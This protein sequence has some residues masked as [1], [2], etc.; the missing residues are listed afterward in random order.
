MGKRLVYL[1]GLVFLVPTCVLAFPSDT[2]DPLAASAG[3]ASGSG[4]SSDH[5][6]RR[7]APGSGSGGSPR[8]G[9]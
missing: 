9:D 2:N 6:G 8:A 7:P 3:S 5:G 4:G 1:A